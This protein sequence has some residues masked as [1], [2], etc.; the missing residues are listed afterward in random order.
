MLQ[1]FIPPLSQ[2]REKK[3]SVK[4]HLEWDDRSEGEELVGEQQQHHLYGK[5]VN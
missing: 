4:T 5:N 1:D 2:K 3:I